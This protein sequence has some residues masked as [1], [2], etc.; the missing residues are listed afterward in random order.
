MRFIS[1]LRCHLGRRPRFGRMANKKT[2]KWLI[3]LWTRDAQMPVTQKVED[4]VRAHF[5]AIA[6]NPKLGIIYSDR[7]RAAMAGRIAEEFGVR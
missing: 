4:E 5:Q 7:D 6:R 2:L 1:Y 3:Y